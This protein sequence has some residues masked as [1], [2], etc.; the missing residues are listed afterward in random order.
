[1]KFPILKTLPC[2]IAVALAVSPASV[3]GAAEYTLRIQTHHSAESLPGRMFLQFAKDVGIVTGN[4]LKIEPF[5]SSSVVK[6]V[7]TFDAASTGIIDCDMTGSSY[8]T[9]KDPAFQFVG[10]LMGGYP[11]PDIQ[12]AWLENGGGRAIADKL[13]GKYNMYLVGFWGQTSESL[14]S[15]KPLRGPA[16][17]KGWKFR[18]P[19]GMETE[20]FKAFGASPV[21]MDFGEVFT[22]MT[23]G[24]V[25]G[26][27][28]STLNTNR[29]LGL[30]DVAKYATYPGWHSMPSDHMACNKDKWNALPADIQEAV[31]IALKKTAH[32][33]LT[34][35]KIE[36]EVAAKE[37]AAKGITL[38]AWS[39]ED[40]KAYRSYAQKV[41]LKW[42]EKSELAKEAVES[43]LAFMKKLGLLKD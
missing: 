17:L 12:W 15:T 31:R 38:H 37:L 39:E 3:V 1:M 34:L 36:N 13:Y 19:P 41:W 2:L 10:D 28:A 42:A 18:S 23:T 30:Y 4:R 9:G 16:D 11:S 8:L 7:E 22:A 43:H 29:S 25:D 33:L 24:I 20:I 26:V 40:I 32:D 21:V 35:S 5:T 6:S 27:D 14:S